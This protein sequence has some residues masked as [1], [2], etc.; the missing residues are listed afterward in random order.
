MS[1]ENSQKLTRFLEQWRKL[2]T[3]VSEMAPYARTI[4]QVE[5]I[6]EENSE[7]KANLANA[8]EAVELSKTEEARLNSIIQ[9]M[10]EKFEQRLLA[11]QEQHT[12]KLLEINNVLEEAKKKV[13][14][15]RCAYKASVQKCSSLERDLESQRRQLSTKSDEY[16]KLISVLG[17]EEKEEDM[18]VNYYLPLKEYH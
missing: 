7:L 17:L 2:Q 13:A 10:M 3:A 8:Q 1:N 12:S 5:G 6:L 11:V 9:G 18:S 14:T 4:N 15:S 16:Q